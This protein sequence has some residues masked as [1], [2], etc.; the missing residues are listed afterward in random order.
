M[1]TRKEVVI[2]AHRV[3]NQNGYWI[4]PL[5]QRMSKESCN[6]YHWRAEEA[7]NNAFPCGPLFSLLYRTNP[8]LQMHEAWIKFT[9]AHKATVKTHLVLLPCFEGLNSCTNASAQE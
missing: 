5:I 4:V 3:E 1:K 6:I 8:G 2:L 9:P 7:I